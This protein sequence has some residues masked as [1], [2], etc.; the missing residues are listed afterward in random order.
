MKK[1]IA[2]ALAL[3]LPLLGACARY[4]P[5]GAFEEAVTEAETTGHQAAPEGSLPQTETAEPV[6]PDIHFLVSQY[7]GTYSPE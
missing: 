1:R 3:L 2:L 7:S 4:E 6:N 5:A